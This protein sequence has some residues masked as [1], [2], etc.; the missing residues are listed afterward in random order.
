MFDSARWRKRINNG[1]RLLQSRLHQGGLILFYHRVTERDI[2]PFEQ[3][4][5]PEWFEAQMNWLSEW[6]KVVPLD[7]MV[8]RAK[9]DQL[10]RHMIS[11]TFDDGYV[12]NLQTALPILEKYQLPATFFITTGNENQPFWWDILAT[13]LL[14]PAELPEKLPNSVREAIGVAGNVDKY[15]LLFK[16]HGYLQPLKPDKQRQVLRALTDWSG[17]SLGER[18]DRAMTREELR[19]LASSHLV[20]HWCAY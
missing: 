20:H 17:T 9:R 15:E 8:A 3:C 5:A 4:L 12:D 11:I 2:D 7:E 19:Q 18:E 14:R 1:I 13:T 10:E 6:A 16:L